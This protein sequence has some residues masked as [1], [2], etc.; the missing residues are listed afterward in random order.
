MEGPYGNT[1]THSLSLLKHHC[2]V[3]SSFFFDFQKEKQIKKKVQERWASV[4]V[5]F[6]AHCADVW[7]VPTKIFFTLQF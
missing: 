5:C 3:P 6:R 1:H 4:A 7:L 2:F